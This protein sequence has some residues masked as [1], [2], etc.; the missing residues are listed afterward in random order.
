MA[1]IDDIHAV[2]RLMQTLD[3][4]PHLLEAVRSRLLTRELLELPQTVARLAERVEQLADRMDQLAD[5]MDQLADRM[6]QLAERVDQIAEQLAEFAAKA[7]RRLENLERLRDDIGALKGLATDSLARR[8]A[9]AIALA[10]NLRLTKNLDGSDLSAMVVGQDLSGI[11]SSQLES[12]LLADLIMETTDSDGRTLY[13][14]VE[15]SY[16]A[17]G[18]DT[19]RAIRNAGYLTRFTGAPSRA[20][21]TAVRTDRN[22]DEQ[23]ASGAVHW[24]RLPDRLLQGI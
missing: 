18:R 1:T 6:D 19:H 24:Y 10:M 11:S 8:V 15:S 23:I 4:N 12:F 7:D 20:A 14:A 16:T 9:P 17:D 2:E 5:R 21:I 22:I 13:V 3:E